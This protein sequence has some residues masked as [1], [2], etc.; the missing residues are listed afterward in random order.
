M[1]KVYPKTVVPPLLSSD[2]PNFVT[3]SSTVLTV[4]KKSLLVSC[5]GFTVYDTKGNLVFRVDNYAAANKA[6]IV[7]MEASGRSVHTIRRKRLTLADS[8]LIYNGDTT[9]NPRFSVTKHVNFMNAKSLAHVSFTG[10]GSGLESPKNGSKKNVAYEIEGSYAQRSCVVYDDKR[11]PV[12]EIKRKEAVG[13]VAFGGDVFR[14]VVQP[15]IDSTVA[16]A[17]VVL[18]DQMF[19]GSSRRFTM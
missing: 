14:L 5:D 13:G 2:R 16:M 18:L 10:P 9:V 11:R 12:A 7:L 19:G 1:T 15:E 17:L 8:W 4:W 3:Q 6:E